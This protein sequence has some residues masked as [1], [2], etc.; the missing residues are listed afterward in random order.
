MH[1]PL[2]LKELKK[3]WN[4]EDHNLPWEKG[5]YS[6]SNT[7]LVDDSPYKAICNPVR[8]GGN[9]R[10]YLEGLAV[11]HDVQLYVQD[12]PFDQKAIADKFFSYWMLNKCLHGFRNGPSSTVKALLELD[13][14]L[15]A[16][17]HPM[18]H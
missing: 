8:P 3:L 2:I 12:H 10:V 11:C 17:D 7:L 13:H 15:I 14:S 5:E 18:L 6:P 9:L 16:E 4:K 1:K